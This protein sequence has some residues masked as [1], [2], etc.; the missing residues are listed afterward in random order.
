M[1]DFFAEYDPAAWKED[2]VLAV[3]PSLPTRSSLRRAAPWRESIVI[4]GVLLTTGLSV[5]SMHA[6]APGNSV[7][8]GS[9]AYRERAGPKVDAVSPQHWAALDRA[10]DALPAVDDADFEIEPF[11]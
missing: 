9:T 2:G 10:V 6:R 8:V 4:S 7:V 3:K 11:V 1:S 5:Q